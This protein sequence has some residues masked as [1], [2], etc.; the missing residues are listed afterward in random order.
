M[1][2]DSVF[3]SNP[4]LLWVHE[5]NGPIL[6]RGYRFDK[7]PT[8]LW[9]FQSF[10]LPFLKWFLSLRDGAVMQLSH[11]LLITPHQWC[12]T[13][14]YRTACAP[15]FWTSWILDTF[16]FQGCG[17]SLGPPKCQA[18]ALPLAYI[19]GSLLA[20]FRCYCKWHQ[21]FSFCMFCLRR[22]CGKLL[23]AIMF[24]TAVWS[25]G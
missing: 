16:S 7:V 19:P 14:S 12:L 9:P 20:I 4:Q 10:H 3:F 1:L 24:V 25:N 17:W 2:T 23:Q 11:L 22:V 8:I 13:A 6:S 15:L 5:Y 18:S 21:P